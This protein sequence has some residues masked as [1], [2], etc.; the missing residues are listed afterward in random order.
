MRACMLC[1]VRAGS[2]AQV[3]GMAATTLMFA[4]LGFMSPANRGGLLTSLLLLF[5]FMGA[6]L[7]QAGRLP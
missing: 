2:G 3:F 1:G 6:W 4:L 7:A 5:V